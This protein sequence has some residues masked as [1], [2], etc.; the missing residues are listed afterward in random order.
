MGRFIHKKKIAMKPVVGQQ[1]P[2]TPLPEGGDM[3]K[4]YA[5]ITILN[6][7]F[8]EAFPAFINS[9]LDTNKWF[10]GDLIILYSDDFAPLSERNRVI[11]QRFYYK[12]IFQGISDSRY[13]ILISRLKEKRFTASL[14]TLEVFNQPDYDKVLYLDVDMLIVG[15]VRSV[16]QLPQDVI[17]TPDS[18][19]YEEHNFIKRPTDQVRFNG[20]FICVDKNFMSPAHFANMVRLSGTVEMRLGEQELLNA[21][22][23]QHTLFMLGTN[24]NVLKRCFPNRAKEDLKRML[25]RI[26]IIHYVGEK[27]WKP[28]TTFHEQDYTIIENLWHLHNSKYDFYNLKQHDKISVIAAGVEDLE[29]Y[30]EMLSQT[31]NF[32]CNWMFDQQVFNVHYYY[33]ITTEQH[34]M[35]RINTTEFVPLRKW[36]LTDN[37]KEQLYRVK[38]QNRVEAWQFLRQKHW[39]AK[40]RLRSIGEREGR[41]LPTSGVGTLLTASQFL[42]DE[43]NI[44]GFNLYT[45]RANNGHYKY[46]GKSSHEHPYNMESKPHDMLTDVMFVMIA[47][48]NFKVQSTTINYYDSPVIE[49]IDQMMTDGV[50]DPNTIVT[51]INEKFNP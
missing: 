6:D 25:P 16:F 50:T 46:I 8:M 23:G 44:V 10:D 51:S 42:T 33:C 48:T 18:R 31:I 32:T 17:V 13:N 3:S 30:R 15:D 11:A 38:P 49:L 20:G 5:L 34:L 40:D 7:D 41:S 37:V 1:R 4:R 14:L 22:L 24:Y 9:F 45:K 19:T 21:Y 27:P 43:V 26:K 47:L 28:K 35:S 36:F 2:Y 39:L 29:Q 12:T